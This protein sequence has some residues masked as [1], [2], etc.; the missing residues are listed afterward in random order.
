MA[1]DVNTYLVM[2]ETVLGNYKVKKER[3]YATDRRLIVTKKNNFSD[4][5]Y[6]HITTIAYSKKKRKALLY[7]GILAFLIGIATSIVSVGGGVGI[8]V[9][10]VIL[11]VLYVIFVKKGYE[12]RTSG[13]ENILFPVKKQADAE[14]FLK[15]VR[16]KMFQ[17]KPQ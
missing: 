16:E 10:G 4:V 8:I 17:Q 5:A 13:G 11:I 9:V 14:T 7:L 2:G 15:T 6:N 12:I 1:E 3:F